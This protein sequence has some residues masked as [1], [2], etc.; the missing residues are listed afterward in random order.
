M[1]AQVEARVIRVVPVLLAVLAAE[2]AVAA[3][4]AVVWR[5]AMSL[6]RVPLR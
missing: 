4:E 2:A 3:A 5:G 6:L 1:A